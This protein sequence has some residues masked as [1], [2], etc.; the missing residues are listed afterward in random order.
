MN[1]DS[2]ADKDG[3]KTWAD[4]RNVSISTFKDIT[5]GKGVDLIFDTVGGEGFE[6]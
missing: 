5:N 1:G 3:G 2:F 4:F 6:K